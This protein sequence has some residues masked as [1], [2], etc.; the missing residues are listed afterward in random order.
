VHGC[1]QIP[2]HQPTHTRCRQ[3]CKLPCLLHHGQHHGHP[4]PDSNHLQQHLLRPDPNQKLNPPLSQ[5]A[6]PEKDTVYRSPRF[7]RRRGWWP[8]TTGGK[9][10]TLM[11]RKVARCKPWALVVTQRPTCQIA[12]LD[13]HWLFTRIG[14]GCGRALPQPPLF[15]GSPFPIPAFRPAKL[16]TW[17]PVIPNGVNPLVPSGNLG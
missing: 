1:D 14:V 9:T 16:V 6:Q 5:F 12:A 3:G 17:R 13:T 7:G 10:A 2:K 11:E 15:S 4:R 8:S